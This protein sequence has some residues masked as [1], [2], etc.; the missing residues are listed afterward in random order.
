MPRAL[1]QK[2]EQPLGQGI[3]LTVG[4]GISKGLAV[5]G[6]AEGQ[7]NKI[8]QILVIVSLMYAGVSDGKEGDTI[9][10]SALNLEIDPYQVPSSTR[11]RGYLEEARISIGTILKSHHFTNNDYNES[12][13]GIYLSVENWSL[14]SYRNSGNVQ[15]TF[16]TYNPSIYRNRSM[17]VNLVA[18]MADGYEGWE[19]AQGDYLPLLGVS[20]QWMYLRTTL[21]LDVVAFG[22]ELP[23]N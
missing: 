2:S 6:K 14:G 11:K 5:Q 12:H 1:P 19:L 4:T 20:A 22:F 18:G 15:S 3:E 8:L 17:Q 7:M 13:E 9:T 21:S 16:L 23:L 10:T